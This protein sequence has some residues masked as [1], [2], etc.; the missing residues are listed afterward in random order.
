[1]NKARQKAGLIDDYDV[2]QVQVELGNE[3]PKLTQAQY[4]VQ[5]A[6][7]NLSVVL[8]IPL[9]LEYSTIGDLNSFRIT[10][11]QATDQANASIKKV[12]TMTPYQYE[13]TP[14]MVEKA[15]ENRGDIRV[16]ETQNALKEREIKAVKS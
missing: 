13:Q 10:S 11:R 5:Q 8:G 12:D 9:E 14:R 7:R 4:A 6:Y 15:T 2:L 1:D 3:Q 16:L